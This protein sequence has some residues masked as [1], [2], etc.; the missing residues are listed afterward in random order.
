MKKCSTICTVICCAVSEIGYGVGSWDELNSIITE[1]NVS[2]QSSTIT[3][4]GD[5]TY[6]P[7]V[8]TTTYLT[9]L[10]IDSTFGLL[11][12]CFVTIDGQGHTLSPGGT[13]PGFFVGGNPYYPGTNYQSAVTLKD[14]TIETA[15][16]HGGNSGSGGGGMGAG[17]ALFV[18]TNTTVTLSDVT[19]SSCS[20]TGG[21]TGPGSGATGSG[22]GGMGGSAN[23]AGGG[24][25]NVSSPASSS[26]YQAGGGC[27]FYAEAGAPSNGNGGGPNGGLA[28]NPPGAGGNAASGGGGAS[29]GFNYGGSGGGSNPTEGG[30]AAYM[31]GYGGYAGQGGGAQ[32]SDAPCPG[33]GGFGGGGAGLGGGVRANSGGGGFGGGGGGA[34]LS[35]SGSASGGGGGFGGGGGGSSRATE[36]RGGYGG[37]GGGG[38]Y[39]FPT[40]N[41]GFGGGGSNSSGSG[42]GMGAGG[43]IFV[44]TGGTLNVHKTIFSD[45]SIVGGTCIGGG[46][47]AGQAYG[48]DIFLVSGGQINFA[49]THDSSVFAIG[50]NYGQG[51]FTVSGS[52]GVNVSNDAG[53][54]LTVTST[55]ISAYEGLFDG[56]LQVNSGILAVDSD[57]CLGYYSTTPASGAVVVAPELNGGALATTETF[58][59][60]RNFSLGNSGGIFKP[61][62]GT[63][64]TLAG[65]VSGTGALI[66]DDIGTLIVS[67]ASNN[68]SGGT[69]VR[70]GTLSIAQI[71]SLGGSSA[72][73]TL[74]GG[75]LLCTANITSTGTFAVT[76]DST[77]NNAGVT[78]L[79]GTVTG[80]NAAI[81]T[82]AGS[83][84]ATISTIAVD[85]NEHFTISGPLGG[86][87]VLT[88]IGAGSFNF[89]E[90]STFAGTTAVSS[91][92]FSVNGTLG[93]SLTAASGATVK[94]AGIIQ[95]TLTIGSGANLAPGNS[96]GTISVGTLS[97]NN[98]STTVIEIDPTA[99]SLID[100]SGVADVAGAL[101]ILQDSG[102]YAKQKSYEIL[103]AGTLNG[104][105]DNPTGGSPG[106]T[107]SLSKLGDSI[108]L[109]YINAI[110]TT[111]LYGNVLTVADYMNVSA[112]PS[113]AFSD[114]AALSGPALYNA[115]NS[116]SPA[117]NAFGPF[118]AELTGFSFNDLII[119]HLAYHRFNRFLGQDPCCKTTC[120]KSCEGW[121]GGF[122]QVAHQD[123]EDQNTAFNFNTEGFIVA[124]D[125]TSPQG[126][127]VLGAGM[128]F[129][130]SHIQESNGLGSSNIPYYFVSLY[131]LW[132]CGHLYLEPAITGD[133]NQVHS[134]RYITYTGFQEAAAAVY[135]QW[136]VIP[137]LGVG[138]SFAGPWC[139]AEPYAAV[140]WVLNVADSFSESG[141][142]ALN[143]SQKSHV[144]SMLQSQ[145]GLRFYQAFERGCSIFGIR[146]MGSYINRLPFGTGTVTATIAGAFD[147][148]T[149]RSLTHVQNLG[150]VTV[151]LFAQIGQ[152]RQVTLTLGYEGE[153]GSSY[154]SNEVIASVTRHF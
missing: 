2:G 77:L 60:D 9:P 119:E 140:D 74:S 78:T 99:S 59:S 136:Q 139:G 52:S 115:L 63:T 50:G 1:A 135:T 89:A 54:K 113:T 92:T 37:F 3:F 81:L 127:V 154:T 15:A 124:F 12:E 10:C 19:F 22:G 20:A 16:A 34:N 38:G 142:G 95:G 43:A 82:L 25:F 151:D 98:G 67:N 61:E 85:T 152:R 83:G 86:S 4:N 62:T 24:G 147:A 101:T 146:E 48:K 134:T 26:S 145:V 103:T 150:A 39:G 41:G 21:S 28:G 144:S 58:T 133:F 108:F 79:S 96:V 125:K 18:N 69:Q 138:Y 111:G 107:F 88:K 33:G 68:F 5:V 132:N 49:L 109:S 29:Q 105:F 104:M 40:A 7:S 116:V 72:P 129:A 42:G 23:G 122:A 32:V 102:V 17:G 121:I 126:N 100:V 148:M 8:D 14:L 73:V 47:G 128:G 71:G 87:G 51:G 131:G 153:Y 13:Y 120:A 76:H 117:R 91:G 110:T 112:P 94:G 45:S 90:G 97:L 53:V 35:G 149:L 44:H 141:A 11:N 143:M 93:G 64:F 137:H 36:S 55:G 31:A 84:T 118:V 80:S 130:Y 123:V 65:T 46:G 6:N 57:Y 27:T 56:T 66:V 114:L 30:G 106:F 70:K 75:T